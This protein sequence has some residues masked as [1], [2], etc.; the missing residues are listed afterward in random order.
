MNPPA[1]PAAAREQAAAVDPKTT[2]VIANPAAGAGR[3]GRQKDAIAAQLK[4]SL[5]PVELLLSSAP[6]EASKLAAEAVRGGMTTVISLG[7]DGTH[8]EVLNGLM[9]EAKTEDGK[10]RSRAALAVLSAGTGG[11]FCRLTPAGHDL[12]AAIDHLR[13]SSCAIIDVGHVHFRADDGSSRSRYF[14]NIAS[15]GI[16]GLVCRLVEQSGKRLGGRV[17][18]YWATARALW[19]YKPARIKLYLD[20]V[21]QPEEVDL[22]TLAVCNGRFAGGGMQFAPTAQLT[23]GQLEVVIIRPA[24]FLASMRDTPHL[25]RGTISTLPYV[26]IHRARKVRVELASDRPAWVDIDGEAPGFAPAEFQV[27]PSALPIWGLLPEA[28]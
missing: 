10:L 28:L 9:Q 11:D 27:Q 26:S 21:L 25:Y 7:G 16:S 22:T 20:D 8:N 12:E 6:G 24:S 13:K 5:G 14:L 2:V 4:K 19:Q 17:A 15:C 18:F 3:V 23:D 1:A